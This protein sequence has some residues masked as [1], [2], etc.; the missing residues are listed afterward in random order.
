MKRVLKGVLLL[1]AVLF[2]SLGVRWLIFPAALRRS[3][4]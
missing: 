4:V 1:L 2:V 3:S